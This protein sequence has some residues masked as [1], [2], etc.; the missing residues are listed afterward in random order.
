MR[1]EILIAVRAMIAV[2]IAFGLIYPLAITGISQVVFPGAAN[3]S[4]IKRDGVTVGSSLIGQ[5]FEAPVMKKG[6]A[7]L[8]KAGCPVW[9]V[10]K[11]YFQT[12]PSGTGAPYEDTGALDNAAGTTFSNLGPNS[13]L[14]L[15]IYRCNISAYLALE[16]P[17]DP[18][19]TVATIPV[20]AI[21]SSASGID[22]DISVA[23]ALVQAHRI[24]AVRHL[25]LTT[26]DAL[27]GRYTT[28]RSLG[29]LGEP[30]VDVLEINLALDRM[31]RS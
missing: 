18:A 31:S 9:V 2:A 16:K 30:G 17:Y 29:F 20:D 3:G 8:D 7:E 11:R 19:L 4:L 28:G 12:R 1:R 10:A 21:N 5:A 23:N 25:S 22:P 14:T 13:T 24:A 6:S 27:V 26:I 15:S